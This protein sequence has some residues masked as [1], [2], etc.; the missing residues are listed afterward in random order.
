MKYFFTYRSDCYTGSELESTISTVCSNLKW[1]KI[2][3]TDDA[4]LVF[5][6]GASL[7]S[8]G[9]KID[10]KVVNHHVNIS[11][12]SK[13]RLTLADAGRGF[14]IFEN[15]VVEFQKLDK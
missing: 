13:M 9:E 2:D 11:I 3:D 14:E 5:T 10:I 4:T 8:F 15:F 6:T 7:K 1:N 12:D